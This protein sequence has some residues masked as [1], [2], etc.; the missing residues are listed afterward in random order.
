ATSSSSSPLTLPSRHLRL[1]SLENLEKSPILRKF[2]GAC[3]GD[4]GHQ[5]LQYSCSTHCNDHVGIGLDQRFGDFL[6]VGIALDAQALPVC[7]GAWATLW[8]VVGI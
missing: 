3:F 4:S 6:I 1:C 2:F 5:I 7:G 8:L